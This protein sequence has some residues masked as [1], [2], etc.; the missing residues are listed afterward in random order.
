M[1]IGALS[2]FLF[3]LCSCVTPAGSHGRDVLTT[4]EMYG[5]FT[6]D[7]KALFNNCWGF[8]FLEQK[9]LAHSV[10]SYD[11]ASST[12]GWRWSCPREAVSELKAYPSL[13]VGDKVHGL[14]GFD[15]TTDSRFP[16]HLP[17]VKSLVALGDFDVTGRGGFDFAFDLL[18]LE[19]AYSRPE[20]IRSEIMV[21]L[22]ASMECPTHKEG[23]Y[24]IEGHGYDL[25]V[26]TDWNPG[27]PYLAFVLKGET[28]P[29]RFA[30][31]EFIRIGIENGYIDQDAYLAAVELGPEIWWGEGKAS[32]HNYAISL[33]G[34]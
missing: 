25:F 34:D 23:E 17:L 12:C 2:V 7:N 28:R 4:D 22:D 6:W 32:V 13:I 10:V 18:F 9:E 16:L 31:H 8:G 15:Q 20:M 5:F 29:R 21:W 30:L 26:N 33:N 3:L 14:P 27:V 11:P 24:I 1:R 19:G